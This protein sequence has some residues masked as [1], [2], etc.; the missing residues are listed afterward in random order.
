MRLQQIFYYWKKV[1]NYKN[2]SKITN[3][4]QKMLEMTS[5]GILAEFG[6]Y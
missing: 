4:L 1:E 6:W 2:H 5:F 3:I